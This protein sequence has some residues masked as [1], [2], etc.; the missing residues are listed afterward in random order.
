MAGARSPR[1][2]PPW[3]GWFQT[4]IFFDDGESLNSD[5]G[6]SDVMGHEGW[7]V[8]ICVCGTQLGR[9]LE[10]SFFT[11]ARHEDEDTQ[12]RAQADVKRRGEINVGE[13]PF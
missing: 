10:G 2:V 11:E 7:G 12:Q 4:R 3:G 6:L 1:G 13:S 9:V 8:P 5:K